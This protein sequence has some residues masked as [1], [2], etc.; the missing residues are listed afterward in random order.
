MPPTPTRIFGPLVST[1]D[2]ESQERLF[3]DVFGMVRVQGAELDAATTRT[4]FD[5]DASVEVEGARVS[6]M[7]TPGVESGVVLVAFTPTSDETVRTWETRVARDALKVIDFYAPDYDAA[8]ARARA[9]GYEVEEAQASYELPEGTFREAHL[10]GPDHVVT[11][12]LGGPAEFF[13]DF[14]QVTDRTVSEVQSIS[15]PLSDAQPAVE[16]YRDVLGWDVVFE[17][18]IDD[19][20]FAQM[21]GV[22]HLVL[23]SRN[24]GPS[25][26]E[27]YFGLIDYG[28]GPDAHAEQSLLGRAVA[29]R[30]GL[31]GAVLLTDSLAEL[32][33]RAGTA[34]ADVAEIDLL[35]RRRGALLR[36]PHRVPHLVLGDRAS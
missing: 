36:T 3:A 26:A 6:V 18:A 4:L 10:W 35:G 28:L 16:F 7:Q 34:L 31:L 2:L 5:V 12:F 21:V 15:A 30:R 9:L 27:P 17:Y 8:I 23:R 32:G 24:I 1:S 11:A 25:T 19:P 14:A 33:H 22:D 13:G 20:S 29:P